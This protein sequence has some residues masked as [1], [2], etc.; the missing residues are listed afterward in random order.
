MT[1]FAELGALTNFSFLEGAS[2]PHEMV[3]TAKTLGHAAIGVA[4]RNSFAGVV[5][6]Q[7]AGK[8]DAAKGETGDFPFL[9]GV[10]LCL[11]DGCEYL[12]WPKDLAAWGR[13]TRLLSEGRMA[14]PKGECRIDRAGLIAHAQGS[15]MALVA[16]EDIGTAF[17]ARL[18][19]DAV[20]LHPHLAMPLFCAVAHRYRGDDRRRLDALARIGPP[21]LAAG[22]ARYHTA[23]R[24]RLADV[25][26]AIR[27]RRTVDALGFAADAN[28]EAHLKSPGEMLR[29]FQGHEE[30]VTNTR[31]IIAA[32]RFQLGELRYQYPK[33][34]LDPGR[35]AQETLEARIAE[36][37][38]DATRW[39]RG[40][41]EKLLRLLRDELALIAQLDYAPYFLTVHEIVRF[42]QSKGILFQGRGSA[43]NSAVCYVLGITAADVEA[44]DLLF[45][46]FL[47]T[48][49][50]EPPDID[51]DFEHERREEVIQHIYER[52]GRDRAALCATLTR[53][54]H[55]GAIREVGKALGLTEDITTGLAK[56][57]WGPRGDRDMA[58]VAAEKGL[59]A[60]AD[61]RLTLAIELAEEIQ[62]FPRHL[63]THVGGFVITEGPLVE[64]AVVSNASMAD[65]TTLEWDKDDIEALRMMKVDVLGLGMLTC[66]RRGFDLIAQHHGQR[67]ALRDLKPTDPR[68]YDMLCKAD[69]VG[70]FQ[71]ESRAQ[72]N[73]LPR[74]KPR[75]FYDL[76]VEV[77]IVRP[78]PIQGDMVHPYLRRRDGLEKADIPSPTD[79]DPKELE[80]VLKNT[81][82]VPLFQEQAMRIAIVAAGFTP[83]EADALRRAMATFRNEGKVAAFRQK[84]IAGMLRRGY[85]QDFAE[86]CFHQIEG[87]GS[88]GFPESHAMS[89]ALLVYAS[90]WVKCHHPAI[91]A[92]ALLNSQPMGFYAPAQIVRDAKDHQ[93]AVRAADVTA[94]D[95]DCTLEPTPDSVEGLALRLGLRLV[96]GLGEEAAQRIAAAR[97]QAP[98]AS[99]AD[100]AQRARLDRG[101]LEAL[102]QADAFRGLGRDRRA[103]LWDVA[104]LS[105]PAPPLAAHDGAEAAPRLPRATAGEQTVLDYAGTGL[106]LRAHPM[107]LLRPQL[108]AL[109]LA[110]T[111]ALNAA[112]QGRRLRLPGLVLVRQRPGSAKGVVFFTVEDEHG[113]ANLVMYPDIAERF[114]AAV[115]ASRLIVAEGRVERHEKSAVPIIHLLVARVQDR[116][117]LLDGLH[118]M[119]E[120]RWDAS[121]ARADEVRR[122]N[123]RDDPR[124][125]VRMPQSRDF[126]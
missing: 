123:P 15:V 58:D 20:A 50:N 44:H 96:S 32:C 74:L 94:S 53:F 73:M 43:A 56:A 61:P 13:L 3:E 60:T 75:V 29:L 63:S 116:S 105:G 35:T 17:V 65:R 12:A 77:A 101:D 95:W 55:R 91:F 39:P 21:L 126:H 37:L 88:Y 82:G 68:V 113:V 112:P 99:I 45:A 72:M 66:L 30:A 16:P 28:A 47:S 2:H 6:A 80:A 81:F 97:A 26:T 1:A 118:L 84:F 51:V 57:V 27:L 103:A 102:A 121:M 108:D 79:G 90:A 78:G 19:A 62:D 98:F 22:G 117:D 5:R 124:G 42:A 48:A 23:E 106:T 4:D 125:R 89:F 104:A 119:E 25:L 18:R 87:F 52:Y 41:S 92:A 109:G 34:V 115:V 122:P 10:R 33:E 14:A 114:R 36:A 8:A 46:R 24:R 38:A 64:L 69:A 67:I 59:D 11:T 83:T 93:V 54:R 120:A 76:V 40:P 107:A 111:R 86:R 7:V 71:V 70:V 100:L 110:D 9:P 49:R 31:R 85:P